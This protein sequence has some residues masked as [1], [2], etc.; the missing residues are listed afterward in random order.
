MDESLREH[1]SQHEDMA[2]RWRKNTPAQVNK[3]IDAALT[4]GKD[5]MAKS[6]S[7][8]AEKVMGIVRE[9]EQHLLHEIME[10]ALQKQKAELAAATEKFKKDFKRYCL[11]MLTGTGTLMLLALYISV[12][13]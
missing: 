8:G 13:F 2:N 4:A 6:M 3:V 12:W 11:W 10:D 7:E 1:L 5:V 9:R